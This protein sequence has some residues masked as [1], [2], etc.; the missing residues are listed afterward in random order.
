MPI[1]TATPRRAAIAKS[2]DENCRRPY[3]TPITNE[4]LQVVQEYERSVIFRLGRL[5]KGGA[6]GPGIFF[7]IPCI[8]TYRKVDCARALTT[9]N[10]HI[11]QSRVFKGRDVPLS[12]CPGTKKFPCPA[13]PLSRDKKSFL[14]PLSLLSRDVPRDKITFYFSQ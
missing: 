9:S 1:W 2:P 13:V 14:V 4:S 8:D 7:V 5:R 6:K 3:R 10:V 11:L 12:L